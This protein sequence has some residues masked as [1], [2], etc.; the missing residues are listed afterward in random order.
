MMCW[1]VERWGGN[2]DDKR[3][4]VF[5]GSEDKAVEKFMVTYQSLRQGSFVE[6]VDPHG[7]TVRRVIGLGRGRSPGD[8]IVELSQ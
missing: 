5:I 4:V 2:R 8:I 1:K 7:R 3:R 6:L